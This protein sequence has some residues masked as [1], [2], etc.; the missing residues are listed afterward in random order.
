LG[1]VVDWSIERSNK[2]SCNGNPKSQ[3]SQIVVD[4]EGATREKNKCERCGWSVLIGENRDP[5]K[6]YAVP[7]QVSK[8]NGRIV[9]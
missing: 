3:I 1:E 7:M 8:N 5:I 6:M 4:R 9:A 2:I